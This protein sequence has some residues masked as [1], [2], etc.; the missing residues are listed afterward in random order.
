MS[1]RGRRT[2]AAALAVAA[3]WLAPA[4]ALSSESGSRDERAKT[5]ACGPILKKP[6]GGK[7][8]CTFADDFTGTELDTSKWSTQNTV[9]SGFRSGLT[10]Y[11]DDSNVE[12]RQGTL[13][14]QARDLGQPVDCSNPYGTFHTRYTGGLVTT[15]NSFAQ[16]YGRFEVRAAFPTTRSEGVHGAFWMYPPNLKYGRWPASGEIDVAEWWSSDPQT[17][18]PTLHYN[19]RNFHADSGWN[20][21]VANVSTFHTYA[22]EW[23]PTGMRFFI[24]GSKC[25]ERKW[26]PAAPQVA[27]QPFDHPFGMILNMGVGTAAGTN[28]VSEATPLPATFI[29]DYARAWK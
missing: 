24:D 12:V 25:Y 20:C 1:P 23:Y 18:L 19:G 22:V 9:K 17:V 4:D 13:R 2:F 27:P 11:R 15:R 5:D 7:W 21:K 8:R 6:G 14:L 10:C 26:R 29:V 3:L 28:V 16:T